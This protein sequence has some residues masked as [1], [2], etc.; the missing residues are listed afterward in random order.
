MNIVTRAIEFATEHHKT[1]IRTG[2]KIPYLT[3]LF[4][5]C[6]IFAERNCDDE[7][8][9]AALLHDIVEDTTVT[10]QVVEAKFGVRVA[11]MVAGATEP[12]KLGKGKL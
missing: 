3:H 6:K 2:T 11:A 8:L 10:I 4:N 12:F 1:M 9:A 7:I 5:V